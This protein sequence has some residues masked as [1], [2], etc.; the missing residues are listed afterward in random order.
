MKTFELSNIREG[1]TWLMDQSWK[2]GD[3]RYPYQV[4]ALRRVDANYWKNGR[5]GHQ[6]AS[7][8]EQ[9]NDGYTAEK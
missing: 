2:L 7:K 8:S 1:G 9:W 3:E 6:R 4:S 5:T